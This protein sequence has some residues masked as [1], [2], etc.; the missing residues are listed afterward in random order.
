MFLLPFYSHQINP[1]GVSYISIARE[2]ASGQYSQA[3]NGYWGPMISWLLVPLLW[4]KLEP[5]YAAKLLSTAVGMGVW[6]G[7][8]HWLAD[9]KLASAIRRI[10]ELTAIPLILYFALSVITPDLFLLGWY[11]LYFKIIFAQSYPTTPRSGLWCGVWGALAFLTKAFAFYFFLAHFL[12]STLLHYVAAEPQVK[13]NVLRHCLTGMLVFGFLS[14]PWI[15]ILSLKYHRLTISTTG[16]YNYALIGPR[17]LGHPVEHLGLIAP[18]NDFAQ[19]AWEDPSLLPVQSWSPFE[20]WESFQYQLAFL[21]RTGLEIVSIYQNFSILW[22]PLLGFLVVFGWLRRWIH[23]PLIQ[24]VPPEPRLWHWL[25]VFSLYTAG[26]CLFLVFDRYLWVN[27]LLFLGGAGWLAQSLPW[28]R[29]WMRIALASVLAATFLVTPLQNLTSAVKGTNLDLAVNNGMYELSEV[30][31]TNYHIGG[32]IAS[33]TNWHWT[34]Y[35][36]YF[37]NAKYYGTVPKGI[38]VSQLERDLQRHQIDYFVVWNDSPDKPLFP[39]YL[40]IRI[41]EIPNLGIYVLKRKTDSNT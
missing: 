16:G 28:P 32:R 3:V 33:D 31:R 39:Q 29:N 23:S 15:G 9:F 5:I 12:L 41:P 7:F 37:L 40:R 13:Q 11:L 24:S 20:S 14:L 36:A 21:W 18:A 4:V 27:Y 26:N 35:L 34:L 6:V 8:A 38:T 30:L 17:S 10:L 22:I 2:Y 25:S 1:D 19:T